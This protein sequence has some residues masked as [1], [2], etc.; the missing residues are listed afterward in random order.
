MHRYERVGSPRSFMSR[1]ASRTQ[2]RRPSRK[3]PALSYQAPEQAPSST[4]F[5]AE[6]RAS[7]KSKT[8]PGVTIV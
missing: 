3:D 4:S 2:I 8:S 5:D 7:E 6:A 1:V